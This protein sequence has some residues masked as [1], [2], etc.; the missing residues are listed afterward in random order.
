[1]SKEEINDFLEKL[2][3][4]EEKFSMEDVDE[5]DISEVEKLTQN[6]SQLVTSEAEPS[7][8][9]VGIKKLHPNAVIPKYSTNGDAGLDL[10]VV[11]ILNE[12]FDSITYDFGLSVEIPYGYVGLLF[13]RSSIRNRGLL[14]SNSV[15]V[16]D[17]GY[18]GQIMVTFKKTNKMENQMIGNS[19]IIPFKDVENFYK[20]G[21]RAAQLMIIPYPQ[22]EFVEKDELSQTDRGDGGYGSTGK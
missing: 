2:K 18:R 14:L 10:T 22:I 17:S 9:K 13:P 11:E 4:Y 5:N 7:K 3:E 1:M 19:I 21:E 6:I 20:V 12:T 15:G 16:L 8:L